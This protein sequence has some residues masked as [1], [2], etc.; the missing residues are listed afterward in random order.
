MSDFR[1]SVRLVEDGSD[2]FLELITVRRQRNVINFREVRA[3]PANTFI[4][5]GYRW[6][7]ANT[8]L[9]NI[10]SIFSGRA[11]EGIRKTFAQRTGVGSRVG[12][13]T[14]N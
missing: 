7:H 3:F 13:G 11:A 9:S 5:R 8:L 12:S 2:S 6:P 10:P 14:G 4:H 1:C